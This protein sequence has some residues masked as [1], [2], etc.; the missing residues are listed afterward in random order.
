MH[1][2]TPAE[3]ALVACLARIK[4]WANNNPVWLSNREGYPRGYREGMFFAHETI[5]EIIEE[6]REQFEVTGILEM[7]NQYSQNE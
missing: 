2:H 3:L 7:L 6:Y 5:R 4:T 1:N